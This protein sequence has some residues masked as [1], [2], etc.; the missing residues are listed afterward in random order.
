MTFAR[1]VLL[2]FSFYR[3]GH[4]LNTFAFDISSFSMHS[5]S[6]SKVSVSQTF[7]RVILRIVGRTSIFLPLNSSVFGLLVPVDIWNRLAFVLTLFRSI[8]FVPVHVKYTLL[9]LLRG[10]GPVPWSDF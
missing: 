10:P 1:S 4:I 2:P 8:E 5:L 7:D 3:G 6:F 9:F